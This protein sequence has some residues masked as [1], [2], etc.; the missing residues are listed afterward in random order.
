MSTCRF[1]RFLRFLIACFDLIESDRWKHE[2]HQC[3]SRPQAP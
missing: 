1:D 2:M 3:S